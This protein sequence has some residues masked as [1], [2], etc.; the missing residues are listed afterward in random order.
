[1]KI[2]LSSNPEII[3]TKSRPYLHLQKV[4][5]FMTT[6]PQAWQEFWALCGPIVKNLPIDQMAGLSRVDESKSGD[7]KFIYQA[8][9]FL[10]ENIN[11]VP[12]PAVVRESKGGKYAK[13]LLTG[14]YD[15]LQYAYPQ[16]F[17]ILAKQ[18]HQ[19]RD[20]FCVEIY[21]NTPDTAEEAELKTE[22]L[23]PIQ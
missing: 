23:I 16:A 15:Q 19:L 13:F 7:D 17:E 9:V 2:N 18:L 1:M 21:L 20:D 12:A 10:T 22:I 6:A 5:S 14:S 3:V 4:G 8:G 11:N